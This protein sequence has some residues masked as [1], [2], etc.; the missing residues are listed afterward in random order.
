MSSGHKSRV[1]AGPFL[2]S[3]IE[4]GRIF[5]FFLILFRFRFFLPLFSIC[6]Q[7][8]LSFYHR[9]FVY[10]FCALFVVC[11]CL[12]CMLSI[13]MSIL[14]FHLTKTIHVLSIWS[15]RKLTM[16][17]LIL[18]EKDIA[19]ERKNAHT[20]HILFRLFVQLLLQFWSVFVFLLFFQMYDPVIGC[21]YLLVLWKRVTSITYDLWYNCKQFQADWN[22]KQ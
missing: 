10:I 18:P 14:S 1:F 7:C 5:S 4:F 15:I 2:S 21:H 22:A 12:L 19:H 11:S 17:I 8:P 9:K 13:S 6:V 16:G 20:F 3:D